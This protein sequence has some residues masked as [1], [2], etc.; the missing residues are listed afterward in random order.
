MLEFIIQ[1]KTIFEDRQGRFCEGLIVAKGFRNTTVNVIEKIKVH[2][3]KNKNVSQATI[4]ET[5]TRFK[6]S[7]YAATPSSLKSGTIQI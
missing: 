3:L 2:G 5:I 4:K 1:T 6:K 7:I